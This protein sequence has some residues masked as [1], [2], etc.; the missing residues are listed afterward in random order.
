MITEKQFEILEM[1][2]NPIFGTKLHVIGMYNISVK[3]LL[4]NIFTCEGEYESDKIC[5]TEAKNKII[6]IFNSKINE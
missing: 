6:E 4:F 5:I 2:R 3:F 1:E